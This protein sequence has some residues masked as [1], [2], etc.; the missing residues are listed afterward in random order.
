[1]RQFI[2]G[3]PADKL[4]DASDAWDFTAGLLDLLVVVQAHGAELPYLNDL[5][6]PAMALLLEQDRAG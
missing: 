4:A 1:M 3:G 5:A 6:V 2:D